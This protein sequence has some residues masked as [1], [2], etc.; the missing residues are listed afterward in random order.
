MP[1]RAQAGRPRRRARIHPRARP[2]LPAAVGDVRDRDA[3]DDAGR[4]R[5]HVRGVRPHAPRRRL[6]PRRAAPAAADDAA[7]GDRLHV[8]PPHSDPALRQRFGAANVAGMRRALRTIT[9]VLSPL[10]C[11]GAAAL[12]FRSPRYL[13]HASVITSSRHYVLITYPGGIQVATWSDPAEP[14]RGLRV[15]TYPYYE[16]NEFGAAAEPLRVDW[17]RFGF[18]VGGVH[19]SN[20]PAPRIDSWEVS[21][22]FWFFALADRKS[23]V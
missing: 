1:R 17:G 7:G 22:P 8:S 11:T 12:R 4:R 10:L 9:V 6:R 19:F 23:V 16:R 2:R 5:L 18:D 21:V 3:R 15:A 13:D 14:A 20:E